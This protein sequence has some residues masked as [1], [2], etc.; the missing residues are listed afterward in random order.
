MIS[1]T[2]LVIPTSLPSLVG[3]TARVAA[4]GAAVRLLQAGPGS[5]DEK[6]KWDV[7]SHG[8]YTHVYVIYDIQYIINKYIYIIMYI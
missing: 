1:S 5:L 7:D 2:S 4:R 6:T 8:T 3:F